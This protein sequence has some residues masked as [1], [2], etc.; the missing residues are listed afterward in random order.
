MKVAH[1]KEMNIKSY[2]KFIKTAAKK[3]C[4]FIAFPEC[5]LQGYTWSWD[6]IAYKYYEDA[7]QR[8]YFEENAETVPGPTTDLLCREASNYGMYIQFGLAEKAS[9]AS[10]SEMFN[11]AV[12]VGPEGLVGKFRKVHMAASAIF[13]RGKEF[14]V[15]ET[16][17]GK[18][19]MIVCADLAYP[20]SIRTLAL[21]GAEMVANSTAWGMR[22]KNPKG[23]YN[24]YR[25]DIFGKANAM[26]NQVWLV[27]SD[28]IGKATNSIEYCYGNSCIIDPA[29][30]V[31]AATGYKEGLAIAA[32]DIKGGIERAQSH[33]YAGHKVL[34]GRRP[35]AYRL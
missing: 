30:Y 5:S 32:V 21:D 34:A 27:Q 2:L 6:P 1:D 15:F 23:D 25:Y 19:G 28:Q 12:L 31:V 13:S 10:S 20:E 17:L 18:V 35:E 14:P 22:G 24:G 7:K 8:V 16:R 33:K 26:M 3:K 9:D 11:S 4:K 29:G